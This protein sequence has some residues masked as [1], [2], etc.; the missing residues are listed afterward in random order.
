MKELSTQEISEVSGAGRLQDTLSGVY[1][2]AFG[3]A[4]KGMNDVFHTDYNVDD[5]KTVGNKFGG[6]L[7]MAAENA[8]DGM[9]NRWR[10]I[11]IG[12]S[13]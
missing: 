1:S 8:F 11:V 12:S 4:A 10:D 13:K 3:R 7:G 9:L 6:T 2:Y 5:A